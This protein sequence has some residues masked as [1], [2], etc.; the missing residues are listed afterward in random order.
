MSAE[1]DK[2][3]ATIEADISNFKAGMES[4]SKIAKKETDKI[5]GINKDLASAMK[6]VG[7][8]MSLFVTA[9][10]TAIGYKAVKMFSEAEDAVTRLRIGL[11]ATG[12]AAGFTA[13]QFEE[14]AN[15]FQKVTAFEGDQI[16]ADVTVSLLKFESVSGKTFKRAQADIL[17]YA[18]QSGIGLSAASQQ[19]GRALE[20]PILGLTLLRRAGIIF[21]DGQK[22]MVKHLVEVG[23][24]AQA[25]AVILGALEGKFHGAAKAMAETTSGQLKQAWNEIG[26]AMEDVGKILAAYVIPAAKAAKELA[27]EFRALPDSTK[28]TIVAVAAVV[29]AIGPLLITI[30]SAVMTF[31]KLKAIMIVGAGAVKV[32]ALS[33][34]PVI[35]QIALVVGVLAAVYIGVTS[36]MDNWKALGSLAAGVCH[37]I[38]GEVEA[39]ASKTV[40]AF[41]KWPIIGKM[42]KE[43]SDSAKAASEANFAKMSDDVDQFNA[44]SVNIKDSIQSIKND[45]GYLLNSSAT[46]AKPEEKKGGKKTD[47]KETEKQ[48]IALS[49]LQKTLIDSLQDKFGTFVS[50][51][52]SGTATMAD[53]FKE[54]IK[55]I[56]AELVKLAAMSIFKWL[57]SG[58]LKNIL[59]G[60]IGGALGGILGLSSKP[61]T[62]SASATESYHG[63]AFSGPINP[64][65]NGGIL[66][67]PMMFPMSGGRRGLAGENR[68]EEGILPLRRNARGDLGVIASSEA[69]VPYQLTIKLGEDS[70]LKMT[71]RAIQNGRLNVATGVVQ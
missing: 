27:Q 49:K 56:I 66:N 2:L 17:D 42:M 14:M 64:F 13:S 46:S 41:S 57:F 35:A 65:A 53:A 52:V 36:L 25:Q 12:G 43:S 22:E 71:G 63:N 31:A 30:G 45:W 16:I 54:M 38:V 24:K 4:A 1:V 70:I 20:D 7:G 9:P 55:S 8:K 23:D 51:W 34:V 50:A 40:G 26:D 6:D 39:M 15:S 32:F 62:A 11:Q 21:S 60:G 10:L 69:G 59:G 3:I 18:A 37:W 48:V 68:Q 19:I 67:G 61:G 29:A 47:A 58:I 33:W 28:K 5:I 44:K